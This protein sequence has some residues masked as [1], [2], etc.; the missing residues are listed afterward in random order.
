VRSFDEGRGDF[1]SA[2][3]II[4]GTNNTKNAIATDEKKR[5]IGELPENR[6]AFS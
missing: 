4:L 6:P 2:V 5:L 3:S 1:N